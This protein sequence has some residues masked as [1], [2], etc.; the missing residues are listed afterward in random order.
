MERHFVIGLGTDNYGAASEA[1]EQHS[2]FF[3]SFFVPI[4]L[5]WLWRALRG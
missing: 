4:I 5:A 3:L 1:I 2:S